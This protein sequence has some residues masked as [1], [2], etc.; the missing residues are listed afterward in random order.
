MKQLAASA[1]RSK[2]IAE[3]TQQAKAAEM[4]LKTSDN[5]C[6]FSNDGYDHNVGHS[7]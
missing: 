4:L 6:T 7:L 3:Q 5:E 1:K 2:G